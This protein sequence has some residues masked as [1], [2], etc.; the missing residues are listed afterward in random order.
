MIRKI[1]DRTRARFHL[2]LSEVAAQNT[3]QRVVLGFALVGSE[4]RV[5]ENG[6]ADVVSSIEAMGLASLAE[7][8][9]EIVNYGDAPLAETLSGSEIARVPARDPASAEGEGGEDLDADWIPESW[10]AMDAGDAGP[11]GAT[12]PGRGRR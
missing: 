8:Q 9:R 3:W 4:R 5:V 12:G 6:L 1:K 10:K 2:S 11:G 7:V